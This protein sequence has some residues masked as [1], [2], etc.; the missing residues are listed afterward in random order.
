MET[1][2][3]DTIEQYNRFFEYSFFSYAS[4]EALHLSADGTPK[5]F[6]NSASA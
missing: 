6:M 4:N 5:E 2:K 3:A 1:I